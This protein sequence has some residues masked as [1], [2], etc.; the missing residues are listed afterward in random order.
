MVGDD[1]SCKSSTV[2]SASEQALAE[3]AI[4][5]FFP[6]DSQE[7]LDFGLHAV[8]LSRVTGLWAGIKIVTNVADGASDVLVPSSHASPLL[9]ELEDGGRPFRHTP[10]SRLISTAAVEAERTAYGPRMDGARA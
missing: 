8:A 9:P 3:L 7:I 10:M 6:A 5:T 1:P 4:P 2:P